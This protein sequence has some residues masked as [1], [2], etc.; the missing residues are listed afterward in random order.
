MSSK[1]EE[2]EDG[3]LEDALDLPEDAPEVQGPK[4]GS[5]GDDQSGSMIEDAI[6]DTE[7]LAVGDGG[8]RNDVGQAPDAESLVNEE[9]AGNVLG[10]IQDG[11]RSDEETRSIPDDSPSMQVRVRSFE[12][13]QVLTAT[14]FRSVFPS[15][16][17][18]FFPQSWLPCE[19]NRPPPAIRSQIS[20]A[21][22]LLASEHPPCLITSLPQLTLSAVVF[23]K[24]R[25]P[26]RSRARPVF[27]AMGCHTVDKTAQNYRTS[28][29]RSW[30]KELWPADLYGGH[31][32]HCDRNL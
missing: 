11:V 18:T 3:A 7:D 32:K 20:V 16:R 6:D 14:G 19:P 9:G 30:E 27:Y 15:Q 29:F 4:N 13:D 25:L 10:N 21:P 22:L 26:R 12:V 24:Y 17:S 2:G 28:V 31:D 1:P 23:G 8:E 5:E